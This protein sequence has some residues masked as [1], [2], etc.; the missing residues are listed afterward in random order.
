[1][2]EEIILKAFH[3]LSPIGLPTPSL[4]FLRFTDSISATH[5]SR[6]DEHEE[7]VVSVL[8]LREETNQGGNLPPSSSLPAFTFSSYFLNLS[9][10]VY[11]GR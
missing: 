5:N 9:T 3:S 6:T 7:T 2:P 4:F 11:Q 8:L 10:A 1:M